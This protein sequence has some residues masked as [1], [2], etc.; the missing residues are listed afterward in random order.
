MKRSHFMI[1]TPNNSPISNTSY[2]PIFESDNCHE[3]QIPSKCSHTSVSEISLD[4]LVR[5]RTRLH[6]TPE[7]IPTNVNITNITHLLK[8]IQTIYIHNKYIDVCMYSCYPEFK[9]DDLDPLDYIIFPYLEPKSIPFQIESTINDRY[10]AVSAKLT[11]ASQHERIC[12]YWSISLR[13]PLSVWRHISY[14]DLTIT[15]DYYDSDFDFVWHN[16]KNDIV[17]E[18]HNQDEFLAMI[19]NMLSMQS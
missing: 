4:A 2:D 9:Y 3:L 5:T 19:A 13:M 18:W 12:G 6:S 11:L 17:T 10:E 8:H 15:M 14:H 16:I 7:H 1:A